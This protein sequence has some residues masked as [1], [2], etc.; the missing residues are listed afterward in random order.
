M[1][2]KAVS[3]N[4]KKKKKNWTRMLLDMSLKPS[5]RGPRKSCHYKMNAV[6]E[7]TRRAQ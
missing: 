5:L 2:I 1:G 4:E 6:S 7:K 3:A